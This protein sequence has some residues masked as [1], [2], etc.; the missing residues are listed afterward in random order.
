MYE[1]IISPRSHLKS[2][3]I[4]EGCN[5]AWFINELK[6][7]SNC[8][9]CD[10]ETKVEE[11]NQDIQDIYEKCCSKCIYSK[12]DESH[13]DTVPSI[14]ICY[15]KESEYY[16]WPQAWSSTCNKFAKE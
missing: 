16:E 8:S 2:F 15:N 14:H 9:W 5:M 12:Y 11:V 10:K 7:F 1:D 13:A 6:E 4:C 3:Y